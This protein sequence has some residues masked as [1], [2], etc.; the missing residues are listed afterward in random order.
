M[1]KDSLLTKMGM[2]QNNNWMVEFQIDDVNTHSEKFKAHL[3]YEDNGSEPTKYFDYD[4]LSE[5]CD[6][7]INQCTKNV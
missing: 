3:I 7:E 1:N 2:K 5:S 4:I 6:P